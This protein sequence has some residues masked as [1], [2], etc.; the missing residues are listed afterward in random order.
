M[1]INC[2]ML[3]TLSSALSL[4]RIDC[5]SHTVAERQP[6]CG[7]AAAILWLSGSHNAPEQQ[8]QR[9]SDICFG[10]FWWDHFWAILCAGTFSVANLHWYSCSYSLSLSLSRFDCGS[11]LRLSSCICFGHFSW[12]HFWAICILCRFKVFYLICVALPT[13]VL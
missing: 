11:Q 6:Y 12:D 5:G 9:S 2:Y 10:N 7:W 3:I 4:T 13:F 8:Q 1:L